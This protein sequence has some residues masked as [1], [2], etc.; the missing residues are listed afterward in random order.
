MIPYW[1]YPKLTPYDPNRPYVLSSLYPINRCRKFPKAPDPGIAR[2]VEAALGVSVPIHSFSL[3]FRALLILLLIPLT[4]QADRSG[5]EIYTTYCAV[6]HGVNLE[7]GQFGGF[8]DGVWNYGSAPG[9]HRRNIAFGIIGTQMGAWD[10]VLTDPEID[11]VLE[12]ILEME[13]TLEIQLPP[14]PTHFETEDYRLKIEILAEGLNQPW[15]LTFLDERKAIFTE[16][17][18]KLRL[19]VDNQVVER[20]ISGT[21]KALSRP[22]GNPMGFMAVSYTHLRAHET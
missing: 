16:F 12:Y 18:G 15:G 20:P 3:K 9:Q 14:P 17:D 5:E 10:K 19:L 4:L 11:A 6:C 8:L 1:L 22:T 2:I 13:R 7:G 21:P